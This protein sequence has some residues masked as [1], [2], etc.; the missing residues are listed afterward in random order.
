MTLKWSLQDLFGTWTWPVLKC[1]RG[2]FGW[3]A[4][5]HFPIGAF[6]AEDFFDFAMACSIKRVSKFVA[7]RIWPA[8]SIPDLLQ[9]SRS[10]FKRSHA[11]AYACYQRSLF[12][13]D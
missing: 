6:D 11:P 4:T 7:S 8:V 12:R 5:S 2:A 10:D 13:R 1:T 3:A 9:A